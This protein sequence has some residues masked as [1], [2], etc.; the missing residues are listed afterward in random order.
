MEAEAHSRRLKFLFFHKFSDFLGRHWSFM[1][2]LNT[3]QLNTEAGC[4]PCCLLQ[5]ALISWVCPSVALSSQFHLPGCAVEKRE[6]ECV[7]EQFNGSIVIPAGGLV[8]NGALWLSQK[9]SK[10]SAS[11]NGK[12]G[13]IC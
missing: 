12:E 11:Y 9:K 8:K 3:D 6:G 10:L 4:C 1:L 7:T 5:C 2:C 13:G